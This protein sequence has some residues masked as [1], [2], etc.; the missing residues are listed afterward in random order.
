MVNI[1]EP[2]VN[3]FKYDEPKRLSGSSQNGMRGTIHLSVGLH[4]HSAR[5]AKRRDR[6]TLK[7]DLHE[8]LKAVHGELQALFTRP[9]DFAPGYTAGYFFSQSAPSSGEQQIPSNGMSVT[10]NDRTMILDLVDYLVQLNMFLKQYKDMIEPNP[11]TSYYAMRYMNAAKRLVTNGFLHEI[12]VDAVCDP[13]YG[14]GTS[15]EHPGTP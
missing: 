6:E 4:G 9:V 1:C 8:L 12:M 14:W 11:M 13:S 15:R 10:P 2:L 7:Q 5:E 3:V